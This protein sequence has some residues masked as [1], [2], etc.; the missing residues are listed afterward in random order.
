MKD[1]QH[2]AYLCT[3]DRARLS[4]VIS[5]FLLGTPGVS[6]CSFS[7]GDCLLPSI[8]LSHQSGLRL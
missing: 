7:F 2:P 1:I 5:G 4:I 6:G 8:H 3:I